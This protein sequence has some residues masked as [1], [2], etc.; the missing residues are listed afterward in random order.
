MYKDS[1]E[2]LDKL[3]AR[4]NLPLTFDKTINGWQLTIEIEKGGE[5]NISR[6]KTSNKYFFRML[7]AMNNLLDEIDRSSK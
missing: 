1:R 3:K 4:T 7:E 2:Q 6:I 5:R